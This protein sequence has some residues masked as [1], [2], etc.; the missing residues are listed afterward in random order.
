MSEIKEWLDRH[1]VEPG[2]SQYRMDADGVLCRVDFKLPGEAAAFAE[3]FGGS[4]VG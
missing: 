4:V 3:T 2:T 1:D